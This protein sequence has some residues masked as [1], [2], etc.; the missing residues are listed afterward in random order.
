MKNILV[1][2]DFSNEATH[3]AESALPVAIKLGADILLINVYPITP[4]LP[5]V[6]ATVLPQSSA[7]EKRR[8]SSSRLN[9]EVRRLEKRLIGL[10]LPGYV[11]A[12]RPIPLEGQLAERVAGLVRRK[13]SMLVTMG[14]SGKSYGDLLFAGNV[15]AV[16]QQVSCP[17]LLIPSDWAGQEIRHILFG[18][19]LA[20]ADELVIEK[21]L[22]LAVRLKAKVSLGHVSHPVLIPDFA[23]E[24]QVSAFIGN[25]A[26]LQPGIGWYIE[27]NRNVMEALEKISTEKNADI[28]ALRYQNHSAWYRLFNENPL[29][30]AIYRGKAPLLIFP[31]NPHHHD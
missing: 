3:A 12:I 19:D 5:P 20:A 25:I 29:K 13:K 15:K 17:V 8:I 10:K 14:V 28:I 23:E 26:K 7:A 24:M 6:E 9:N 31:E 27:R 21:L 4:Y 1:L 11:P 18:T 30:E 22:S 2:T 16:L